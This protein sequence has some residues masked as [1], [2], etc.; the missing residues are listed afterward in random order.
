[1]PKSINNILLCKPDGFKVKH[2]LEPYQGKIQAL[3]K[4]LSFKQGAKYAKK[5][6]LAAKEEGN[7][8]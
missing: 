3:T 5:N 8:N 2:C 4:I 6:L 7:H 1:V